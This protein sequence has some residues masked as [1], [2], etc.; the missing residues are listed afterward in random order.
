MTAGRAPAGSEILRAEALWKRY[1]NVIAVAGM[2]LSVRAGEVFSFLGPNGSG[3]STTVGMV[4]GLIRP[5]SGRVLAFGSDMALHPWPTLK[6]IGAVIE[7]P[8][9]YPYLSGYDNL[10]V[11]AIA[12]GDVPASRINEMLELV[13]LRDRAGDPFKTYSL[14][15]KQRLGIASTLLRDPELII[16]DE[17][18]N[19]LDPAGT[20]E[21]RELIPSLAHEGRTVF[22]CSHLLHEVQQVSDRVAIVKK[23]S[24]VAEGTVDEL[25]GRGQYLRLRA[26]DNDALARALESIP[27]VTRIDRRDGFIRAAV[28]LDQAGELNRTLAAQEIFLSELA[29]W[30][31]DLE[32]VFLQLTGD[33]PEAARL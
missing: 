1:G 6:R 13:G 25:L 3:K 22:L 28:N 10:R 15:M 18:T 24:V 12:L 4:L 32:E 27:W 21:V 14:G 11:L 30:E 5:T 9:F 19:G 26:S 20:A 33:Q 23:G 17:P 8:A 31:S 2:D 16:L 7:T 29:P